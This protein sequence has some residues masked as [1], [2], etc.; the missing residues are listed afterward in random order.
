M[1]EV[2]A[3]GASRKSTGEAGAGTVIRFQDGNL[4]NLYRYL[5]EYSNN[6]AELAAVG[7][8]LQYLLNQGLQN[9]SVVVWSD[10]RYAIGVLTGKLNAR[11]NLVLIRQIQVLI[12]QFPRLK[13]RWVRGH[14]GNAMNDLADNLASLAIFEE[15]A[16]LSRPSED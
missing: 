4:L 8:G 7:T 13:F 2:W 1:I 3:D 15:R 10:S 16:R 6:Y 14:S 5:G 9:E 11:E 12:A